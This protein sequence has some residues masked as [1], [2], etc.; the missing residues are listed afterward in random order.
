[1]RISNVQDVSAQVKALVNDVMYINENVTNNPGYYKN[2]DKMNPLYEVYG[3]TYLDKETSYHKYYVPTEELVKFMRETNNPLLRVYADPRANM[4]NDED[5][6]ANYDLFGLENERYI[7]VPYGMMAPAG[8][9]FASKIGLGVLARSSSKVD[10]PLV[11]LIVMPGCLTGFYLAEAALR[12][13]IDGG[14]AAAKSYYEQA[15]TAMFKTYERA[16]QDEALSTDAE[17]SRPAITGTAAEAAAEFLAQDNAAVNWD[18]MTTFEE[19]MHAI[20]AQ[21]WLGLYG[22]D[23]IEAWSEIRRTDMP[24]FLHASNSIAEGSKI[25]ARFLYPNGEKTLNPENYVD[26]IDVYNDLVFWDLKNENVDRAP[27][28]E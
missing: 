22:I 13:M 24:N 21:K 9:K 12:G 16:L 15:V 19:K 28:Y 2:D 11:D 25:I 6:R 20:Q 23:P 3:Y 17:K 18:L 1:M 8:G 4:G 14:D 7:G 27:T 5:G 10:G 26:R